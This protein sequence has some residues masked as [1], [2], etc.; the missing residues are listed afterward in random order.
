MVDWVKILIDADNKEHDERFIK[1]LNIVIQKC[2]NI[3][4]KNPNDVSA[5]FFKGGALGFR[6][7][8]NANRENWISAAN[9]GRLA[10][11]IVQDA[12]KIDPKNS[13]VLLG[14]GI[15]N[16]YAAV[17]PEKYPLVKP[18]MYF[19]PNGDKK[20]GI[21]QIELAAKKSKYASTEA[22]YFLMQLSYSYE[23]DYIKANE[24][25]SYLHS[26]FEKN[27]VFHRYLG[28]TE[29]AL[30][31]FKNANTIF[32]EILNR[33]NSKMIK[34][35]Y[36]A[37]TKREALYYLGL[38]AFYDKQLDNSLKYFYDCDELSRKIDKNETS[39]FMVMTNLKIGMIYDLQKKRS[40]AVKQYKKVI[41]MKDYE[42]S[43]E[44][45]KKYIQTSFK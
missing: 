15:Y 45:A 19:F 34:S 38:I 32:I 24:I 21:E 23:N 39:G 12:F 26:Q 29:I 1:K 3:L 5:L 36:H 28:R 20:K 18:V 2:D 22:S 9:D 42:K 14:I 33:C 17:I 25:A 10:L 43:L 35:G 13:D 41:A 8:L 31:R 6:G 30:S 16:Y 40:L 7:R 37:I 11:P 27:S 4:D 44:F